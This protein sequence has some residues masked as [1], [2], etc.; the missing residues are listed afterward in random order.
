MKRTERPL[1]LILTS[2]A[3][4]QTSSRL[5]LSYTCWFSFFSS[6][7]DSA[8]GAPRLPRNITHY[9]PDTAPDPRTTDQPA[10]DYP[11]SP[12]T[13][14]QTWHGGPVGE[15]R[16]VM[17]IGNITSPAGDPPGIRMTNLRRYVEIMFLDIQCQMLEIKNVTI[18]VK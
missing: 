2:D 10:A 16:A 11:D 1:V 13:P 12:V 8:I 5:T 9:Q 14:P 7:F 6:L 18:R 3:S 15:S 17:C 4:T